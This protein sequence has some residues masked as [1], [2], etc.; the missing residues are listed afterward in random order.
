MAA[1]GD[2]RYFLEY[3]RALKRESTLKWAKVFTLSKVSLWRF[4]CGL[5]YGVSASLKAQTCFFVSS[6]MVIDQE[7]CRGNNDGGAWDG[8]AWCTGYCWLIILNMCIYPYFDYLSNASNAV[9]WWHL[10][11]WFF[12]DQGVVL[13]EVSA[14]EWGS[15]IIEVGN[16]NFYMC[17]RNLAFD[18][19]LVIN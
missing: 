11:D 10:R 18:F 14:R 4:F 8:E 12:L 3:K 1:P 13:A 2:L 16:W 9:L 15:G 7:I 19:A 5:A 6:F 17:W